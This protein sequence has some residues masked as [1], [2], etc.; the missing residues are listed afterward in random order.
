[1][2]ET[3]LFAPISIKSVTARNR[4]VVAPMCQYSAT[5][6]FANDWHLVH[7]GRF[8]MG[9]AAMVMV[10]ATAVVPEGRIT[11]GD[12]G[13]W[14]DAQIDGLARIARFI[15]EQGAVAAI[16]LAHAGRKASMQR[17]WQG[18]GPLAAVDLESGI[19]PWE[20]MAPSAVPVSQGWLMPREMSRDDMD[21]VRDAWCAAARR[22]LSAGFEVLEVHSAHGYLLH[23][24]L[25]PISN[26]R[27]D[28]YGGDLAGRC[29]FP[30]EVVKAV[31]EVWPE[32][33]PLFV[34]VS[35]VDG[36]V[37]GWE[38]DDTVQYARKL[39]Q[40][41]VDVV[42]CSSG[43]LSESA[44]AASTPRGLGFQVPYAS[45]VKQDAE[46][47]T[48]AVGLILH[49]DQ[50]EQILQ[51]GHADLIAIGREFMFNPNWPLHAELALTGGQSFENWPRQAGW[52]L[53]RRAKGLARL[54][55]DHQVTDR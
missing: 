21:M 22:A 33:K 13:L 5:D 45:R 24:F 51:Q 42:D 29:R 20:V 48:M 10:E 23:S 50:A 15:K 26:R 34:R 6:G 25:S 4:I 53:E 55:P 36:V 19:R 30:L 38:I 54:Q 47:M 18:N 11:H 16:Q 44:T 31:R 3:L 37:G 52:W 1:M 41:G 9:G 2:S 49:P 43:G 8:A 14:S 32:D 27:D 39:A 7:L 46:V 28:A 17:P 35:S 12:L 40:L